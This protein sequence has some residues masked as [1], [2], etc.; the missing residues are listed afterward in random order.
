MSY[1]NSERSTYNSKIYAFGS[2]TPNKQLRVFFVGRFQ[3]NAFDFDFGAGPRYP[4]V[5]PT[6]LTASRAAEA[7]LCD[8]ISPHP[9]CNAPLDPGPGK[10]FSMNTNIN[11]Q[12]LT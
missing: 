11:Y 3:R 4:R 10:M 7:G 6:A 9:V 1:A 2:V 12:P 8:D 5:S